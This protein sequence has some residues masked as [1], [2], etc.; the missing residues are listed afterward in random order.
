VLARLA[1]VTDVPTDLPCET[2]GHGGE[3]S[4]TDPRAPYRDRLALLA[5]GRLV[6]DL[7][8]AWVLE[9]SLADPGE[10]RR[11]YGKLRPGRSPWALLVFQAASGLTV[12]ARLLERRDGVTPSDRSGGWAAGELGWVEL[13]PSTEDPAL[14][15]LRPVLASLEDPRVVRYHP[16]NRCIVHGGAGA[17]ERYVK[18]FAEEV[19]DQ[20]EARDR[21]AAAASGAL[22]FAVAEPQGW[23]EET[24]SSWYG[25][26]PGERLEARLH[27]TSGAD[28]ARR[29]G[30]SLGELAVA[31][32]E[33]RRV[34]DEAHQLERTRRALTRAW[35]AVPGLEPRLQRAFELLARAHDPLAARPL[36]PVHGAAHLGQW[37][38]DE[39]G[40][41]GLVDFDRYAWGEPEFDL[42]T[43]LVELEA[44]SRVT[45]A[46]PLAPAAVEGFR[47][48][49]GRL[50]DDRLTVYL[51]H[52]Q[53]ARVARTA[54]GLRP[55]GEER[56]S[57]A[58]EEVEEQLQSGSVARGERRS[59]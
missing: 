54:A 32:L 12:A 27:S 8:D 5:D 40:R 34:D 16:G 50:D 10:W 38:V 58:L 17:A 18:V 42:A 24:R 25:A 6:E 15:G 13:V 2:A 48:V 3:L 39:S 43:F 47:E 46:E 37:L 31:G 49:A 57:R 30:R 21:W 51:L 52:K 7:L 53:L 44:T 55:D 11:I 59:W 29:V 23:V 1:R 4:A 36:V 45:T 9:Q 22:S 19:D 26:V 33:P 41:L 28:L 14:P 20:Q 35:T 56:A